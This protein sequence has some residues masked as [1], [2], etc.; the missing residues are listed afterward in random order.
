MRTDLK[1]QLDFKS[2]SKITQ[3]AS[4]PWINGVHKIKR[5]TP[6][7]FA[8][9]VALSL[10]LGGCAL[11]TGEKKIDYMSMIS[12]GND[13]RKT[14][15]FVNALDQYNKAAK[16]AEKNFGPD[17]GQVATALGYSAQIYRAQGEWR[18][19]YMTYKRLIP[20]MEKFAPNTRETK[21]LKKDFDFVKSKIIEYSIKTDDNFG[22][23]QIKKKQSA[24]AS[25]KPKKKH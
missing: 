16:E 24:A 25:K 8:F 17:S 19:A 21:D 3:T 20:L 12:T 5:S 23:D 10:A 9:I 1:N 7:A 13:Y 22:A 18:L 14:N 4:S 11:L 2:S 15:D 6:L